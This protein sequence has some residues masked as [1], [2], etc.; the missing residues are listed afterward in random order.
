L[1]IIINLLA[2]S[3]F[4]VD[5]QNKELIITI[6]YRLNNMIVL[7]ISAVILL[8]IFMYILLLN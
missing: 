6:R 8:L 7:L 1:A 2:I 3:H 5:K 4:Y